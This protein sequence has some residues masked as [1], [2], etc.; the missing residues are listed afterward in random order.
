VW[1]LLRFVVDWRWLLDRDDSPWYPSARLFRQ[2]R[3]CDWDSVV[4]RLTSEL[5]A[6]MK[7][8]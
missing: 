6:T 2:P 1:I 4:A 5:A 8:Q 7:A 3:I